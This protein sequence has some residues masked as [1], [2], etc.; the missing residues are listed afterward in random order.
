MEIID[1]L[2]P[3]RRHVYTGSIGYISFHDTMDLSIAIR[4]A[5]IFENRIYFSVGGGIVYDSDPENEFE[6]TLHKGRTLMEVFSGRQKHIQTSPMVWI[7]GAL[8][9]ADQA[10]V[11]I[12]DEGFQ[13][14]YGFFETI[15][16]DKGI[17]RFLDK[18]MERFYNSWR[19]LF[20][21]EPPDLTWD[22]I[23]AQVIEANAFEKCIASVK[24]LATRGSG[25]FPTQNRTLLAMA[26][27]YI[28]R[29]K[30]K[31]AIG[32]KL[33]TY[34]EPRQSPLADHKSLN[35]LY[36]LNAGRWAFENGA[37]EALVINPDG[38]VSETNTAN[39]LLINR[40]SVII[41]ESVH[42][43]PGIFQ[44]AA[45]D[46]LNSWGYDCESQRVFPKDLLDVDGVILTNSLMGA[47]PI[48][49][50]NEKKMDPATVMCEKINKAI[51]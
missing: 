48:I 11:S 17:P 49:G 2:E 50:L 40:K 20:P 41:P 4:T 37:D 5:T 13:Y 21:D 9:L 28:H 27:L 6:E 16:V 44:S 19:V 10:K 25:D 33:L 30:Q 7:N 18:H 35:Y 3:C 51:L 45:L 15:R 32:L 8:S 47:V 39:I 23:I 43:L 38:S 1:E 12:N 46:L 22:E 29:L 14:G 42:V 24:I 31:N 26:K 34:P 36:Y